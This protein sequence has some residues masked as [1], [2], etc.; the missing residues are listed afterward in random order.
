MSRGAAPGWAGEGVAGPPLV[1]ATQ[2]R[3]G[4]VAQPCGLLIGS[5]FGHHKL[6]IH[7]T[8]L[9]Q[10]RLQYYTHFLSSGCF[11]RV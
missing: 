4:A 6:D 10:G 8:D 11:D 1:G 3:L 5:M 2:S 9:T 7:R